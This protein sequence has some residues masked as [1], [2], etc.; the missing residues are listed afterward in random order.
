MKDLLIYIENNKYLE[1][2]KRVS[3]K[4]GYEIVS[5]DPDSSYNGL[6]LRFGEDGCDLSGNGM[7]LRADFTSMMKRLK[8]SNLER[9]FLVRAVR[10]KGLGRP[11]SVV[12]ATAG[13]GEDSM[14]LAA[15][16]SRV[17]MFEYNPVIAALLK[18]ALDR[19]AENP[20]LAEAAAN[21]TFSG[22]DSIAALPKL[23]YEPDVVVLDPMFPE[24]QK[25][26]LIKKK[27]QLLQ[28]LEI[29]C[30][31]EKEL[32]DAAFKA[33]PRKIVIKRPLKGPYLAGVRPGY[34][35]T[36]KAVRYDCIVIPH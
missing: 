1:E 25:S 5:A 32:L 2:A 3:E 6:V 24:R 11:L 30:A 35:L 8:K 10:I 9:E 31:E 21:I 23:G 12:D 33:H 29:P 19:A 28:Q 16:G 4:T 22:E 7:R 18:D 13:L 20:E 15:S 26:A 34:S 17:H 14:L 27:F 36:G